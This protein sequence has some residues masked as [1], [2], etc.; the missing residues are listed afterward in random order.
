MKRIIKNITLVAEAQAK[1]TVTPSESTLVNERWSLFYD[2]VI[3]KEEAQRLKNVLNSTVIPWSLKSELGILF[4]KKFSIRSAL[5]SLLELTLRFKSFVTSS[6]RNAVENVSFGRHR[7]AA[8]EARSEQTLT[9]VA[10]A[11]AKET[12]TPSEPTKGSERW[13]LFYDFVIQ[14]EEA[15]RL[16][17]LLNSNVIPWSLKSEQG[18]SF[19]KTYYSLIRFLSPLRYT[20]ITNNSKIMIAKNP[21]LITRAELCRSIINYAFVILL[22]LS[23]VEGFSQAVSINGTGAKPDPSAMLD[24][25]DTTKGFLPPRMTTIQR[26]AIS[27]PAAGLTIYNTT[28]NCLQWWNGTL[29]YDG[30]GNNAAA[31]TYPAGTVHCTGTPT[32]VVDVTNPSTGKIWMDRNLGASQAATS[33]TDAAAYGDLYQ[34]GRAADGHQCRNSATTTTLSSTDTPANGNFIL[35]PN[36]P[37]DWRSPQN[38][39]LWQG[40]NGVNNPCPSGYR[41]PTETELNAERLSWSSSNSAGAFAS[42]LKLPMAGYR[43]SSNGSLLYVGAGGDYWSGSVSSTYSRYLGFDSGSAGVG[44]FGRAVGF[45]VRCLKD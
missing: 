6:I 9:S 11:I 36:P 23:S 30:C 39:N 17:N 41:L 38:T 13:S 40:V 16:K 33:S 4:N 29:W 35:A 43:N 24:V 8:G 2:F 12:V 34:W 42:P 19:S 31:P 45:S 25:S 37:Y 15:Q 32:A 28:V 20:G 1:E 22:A 5:A 18:I 10:E 44:P 7:L 3:Q 27:S 26:D 21:A 14:K